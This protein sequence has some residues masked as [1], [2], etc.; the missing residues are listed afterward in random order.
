MENVLT[1]EE[2]FEQ[3]QS[4]INR[5]NDFIA[6]S[7]RRKK[8]SNELKQIIDKSIKIKDAL[9]LAHQALQEELKKVE[10]DYESVMSDMRRKQ[11]IIM[12]YVI[13]EKQRKLKAAEEEQKKVQLLLSC[14]K[15]APGGSAVKSSAVKR[16]GGDLASLHLNPAITPRLKMSDY[17]NLPLVKKKIAPIPIFFA[18]FDVHISPQQFD[19]IPKYMSGRETVDQ[20]NGFLESVIIPC[21]NEKYQLIHKQRNIL[22]GNDLELWKLYNDQASYLPGKY[23]ITPGD[24]SRH[25]NKMLDKKTQNRLTML[26][27]IGILQEQRIKQTVCYVWSFNG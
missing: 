13:K 10:D 14:G 19:K 7:L 22:R 21:F 5:L 16:L 4:K 6:L 8:I 26:R 27:H 25:Q 24:I 12:D 18:E 9:V 3:I 15:S 2:F 1:F 20:L 23:F 17:K 11:M